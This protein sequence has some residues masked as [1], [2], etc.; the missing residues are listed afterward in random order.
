MPVIARPRTIDERRA[1][2]MKKAPLIADQSHF[3]AVMR[4]FPEE[5]RDELYEQVRSKLT[6]PFKWPVEELG[7]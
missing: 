1:L 6:K 5:I 2:F 7:K 3:E 4:S